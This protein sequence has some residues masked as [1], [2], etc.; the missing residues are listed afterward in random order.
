M[1]LMKLIVCGIGLSLAHS[2]SAYITC[3]R[4]VD[5]IF[6]TDDG[7]LYITWVEGGMGKISVNDADHKATLALATVAMVSE[8]TVEVRYADGAACTDLF[9]Q[10][11]GLALKR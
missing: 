7:L 11:D 4:T 1:R 9:R 5:S 10:I 6:S 3:V 8:K 2:A